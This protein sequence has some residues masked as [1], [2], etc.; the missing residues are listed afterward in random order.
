MTHRHKPNTFKHVQRYLNMNFKCKIL[1]RAWAGTL[2][3]TVYNIE[4]LLYLVFVNHEIFVA[5]SPI[6]TPC[7]RIINYHLLAAAPLQN[8][9]NFQKNYLLG[10][11][12]LSL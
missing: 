5:I 7:S 8:C 1:L 10:I 3:D 2:K 4:N 6:Y 11:E 9:S 12:L